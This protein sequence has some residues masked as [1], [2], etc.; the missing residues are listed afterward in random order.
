M[1]TS[2]VAPNKASTVPISQAR[3]EKAP[4]LL[5]SSYLQVC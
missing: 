2:S 3:P 1:H 4:K 5:I